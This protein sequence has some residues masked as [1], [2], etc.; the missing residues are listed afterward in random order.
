MEHRVSY[1]GLEAHSE[2]LAVQLAR[3][4]PQKAPE[5]PVEPEKAS[6]DEE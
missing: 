3:Q 2:D 6:S 1:H 5:A 4:W